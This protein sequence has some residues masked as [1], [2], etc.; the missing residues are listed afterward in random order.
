MT[1]RVSDPRHSEPL[2][3]QVVAAYV[4]WRQAATRAQAAYERWRQGR[5]VDRRARYARY[6]AAL[7]DEERAADDFAEGV[8]ELR[9]AVA[10]R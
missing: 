5:S 10:A 9:R 1:T 8:R 6:V 3:E 7:T 2:I 4:A